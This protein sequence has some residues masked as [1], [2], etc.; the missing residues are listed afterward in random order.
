[1]TTPVS[2]LADGAGFQDQQHIN[3][4]NDSDVFDLTSLYES[5]QADTWDTFARENSLADLD[6]NPVPRTVSTLSS[7]A[8]ARDQPSIKVANELNDFDFA[9]I[10]ESLHADA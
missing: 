8:G 6:P 4:F 9:S 10:Y 3:V 5:L 1:M 2:T 7:G